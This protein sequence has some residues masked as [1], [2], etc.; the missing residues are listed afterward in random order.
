VN[1]IDEFQMFNLYSNWMSAFTPLQSNTTQPSFY[2]PTQNV[3]NQMYTPTFAPSAGISTEVD[4]SQEQLQFN[5]DR[6]RVRDSVRQKIGN[7]SV[8][9]PCWYDFDL[10]SCWLTLP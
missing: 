10:I 6:D 1:V 3:G 2:A 7:F 5:S 8:R 9:R 4:K